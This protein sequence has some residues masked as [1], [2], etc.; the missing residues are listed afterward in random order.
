MPITGTSA[1]YGAK[2]PVER[3]RNAPLFPMPSDPN[4][5]GIKPQEREALS[6]PSDGM[7]GSKP[8]G[9]N[10]LNGKSFDSQD[11]FKVD[12][13]FPS[14]PINDADFPNPDVFGKGTDKQFNGGG[15]V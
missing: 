11:S 5:S 7:S 13:P 10:G 9:F 2:I 14:E 15:Y 3:P 8:L 1:K 6:G 4:M 12:A